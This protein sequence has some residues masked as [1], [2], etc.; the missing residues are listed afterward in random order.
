MLY[1]LDMEGVQDMIDYALTERKEKLEDKRDLNISMR[2]EFVEALNNS[3]TFSSK[4][5]QYLLFCSSQ[6]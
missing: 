4:T 3:L 5:Y 6:S 2:D 1:T